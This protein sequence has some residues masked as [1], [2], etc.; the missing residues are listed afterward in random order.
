MPQAQAFWTQPN[1]LSLI[2][3]H[4][5]YLIV[6]I[7]NEFGSVRWTNN[8]TT[9]LTTFKNNYKTLVQNLRTSGIDVPIMI[10]AP[11]CGQSS[12]EL[13]S[14]ANEITAADPLNKM[15][16]SAH[17]YWYG[18]TPTAVDVTNKIN[19][20]VASN[21][22]FV[23]GEVAN[24]QDKTGNQADGVYN[25]DYTYQTILSQSCQKDISWLIWAFN[26]DWNTEREM[27]PTSNINNLTPFGQ[28]ILYNTNYGLLSAPCQATLETQE[29]VIKTNYRIYP[30][31]AKNKVSIDQT[32]LVSKVEIYDLNGS[33]L[34]TYL[35]GFNKMDITFLKKGNY[36]LLI[37]S[38]QGTQQEKLLVR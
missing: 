25:I 12:S 21:V 27:T 22:P 34:K 18:Y 16:Y 17:S 32:K 4:K 6:N 9:S 35:N 36:I 29:P 5:Q 8:P 26:H 23:F 31:P 20:V 14:V 3:Q 7:A 28:D 1:M 30:N 38:K 11:D 19:E 13:L 33:L 10:D 2:Q 15:I 37:Y 24:R